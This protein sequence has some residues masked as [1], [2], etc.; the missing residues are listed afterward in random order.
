LTTKVAVVRFDES[1]RSL[2]EALKLLGGIE[3]LNSPS[4]PVVVKVGVFNHQA[5]NHTSVG[6]LEAIINSFNKAPRIYIAESDNYKGTG[7]ERLQ[8]W[9]QLFTDRVVPFNLS[10][11]TDTRNVKVADEQVGLSHLL[12]KP[13]VIVS[14]HILR[15]YEKGSILKNLLGLIPDPKKARFHKK[16][17][18]ALLDLYEAIDGIDLAVMDGTYLYHGVSSN[19]HAGPEDDKYRKATN[20]VLVGRDAV[21]V[22]AVGFKIAGLKPEKVPIIKEAVKRR[23]GVGDISELEIIGASIEDLKEEFAIALKKFKRSRPK[24]PQTWGG[25]AHRILKELMNEGFFKL[26]NKRTMSDVIKAL[27]SKGLKTEGNE[28]RIAAALARK[29]KKA[30]LHTT[31]SPKGQL[32]WTE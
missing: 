18:P 10:D 24:G 5:Q 17:E 25:R 22:E 19:S 8:I 4:R 30:V 21:A 3:D 9:K 11:D 12:F 28:N 32:Y 23:I 16:L 1:N 26:P 31:K 2:A 13:N 15:T 20:I 7:M 29:M 27:E 6:V 14:T